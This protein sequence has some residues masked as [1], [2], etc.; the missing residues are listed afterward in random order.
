MPVVVTPSLEGIS[1]T[2]LQQAVLQHLG[3][4]YMPDEVMTLTQLGLAD[5]PKTTSGKVQ[6]SR[7]AEL[8]RLF[9]VGRD[10]KQNAPSRSI[11]DIILHAYYK[12]TGVAVENLDLLTP[13]TNFADSISFMRVR[14]ALRK[15]LGFTLTFQ[16][17][18]EYPNIGSQIRLLQGRHAT[19]GNSSCLK[20]RLSG[21]PSLDEMSIAFGNSDEATRMK[22]IISKTLEA[23]G[24]SWSHDVA[25]IIPAHDFLQVLLELELIST[26]NFAIAIM[27]DGSSTQVTQ[28]TMNFYL[29]SD[30]LP[31]IAY[32]SRAGSE[33]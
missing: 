5:F 19:A 1:V 4:A 12:S 30:N 6:K 14:D 20:S 10:D 17:M 11:H 28:D 3:T 26:W 22:T 18:T 31:A 2:D 8:V 15:Q 23:K 25:S 16:E 24:F 29:L 27:A 33:Q 32:C 7:L 9:R 13:V 21:P